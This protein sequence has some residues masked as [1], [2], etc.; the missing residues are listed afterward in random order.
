LPLA[1]MALPGG[2]PFIGLEHAAVGLALERAPQRLDRGEVLV[3]REPHVAH[4]ARRMLARAL[5]GRRLRRRK[6]HVKAN[7]DCLRHRRDLAITSRSASALI[8]QIE[9]EPS[10]FR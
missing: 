10:R 6:R 9:P 2:E 8:R 3:D 4:P 5:G 7:R 1:D